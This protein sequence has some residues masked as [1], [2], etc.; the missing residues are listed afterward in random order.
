MPRNHW[1]P[2]LGFLAATAGAL[3]FRLPQLAL[4]PMHCD[5]GNQALKA[6]ILLETGRYKY[7]PQEHHGPLLYYATLPSL[8]LSG[9][10]DFAQSGQLA[11]RIVPVLFGVGLVL[12]LP[13]AADGLGRTPAVFAG[14]L[15]AL[16]PA[17][18]FYSRYYIQEMLLVLLTFAAIASAWR[19]VRSRSLLWAAA[20]GAFFGLMAATK[21]TWCLAAAAMG[22][23]LA[24]S[25]A[26][27][28]WRDG[29]WPDLRPYRRPLPLLV[30]AACGLLVFE[31]FYSSLGTNPCGPADAVLAYGNY[32]RR[33]SEGGI[34][35]HPWYYYLQI[36]AAS[37]PLYLQFHVASRPWRIYFGA[38]TLIVGLAAA[39][40]VAALAAKAAGTR[41][42]PAAG[43]PR[44]VGWDKLAPASAGPPMSSALGGPAAA[45]AAWSHPTGSGLTASSEPQAGFCRFLAFYTLALTAL[46]SAL[47]YKTPWCLLSFLHGMILL[48]GF[49]GWALLRRTPSIPAKVIVGLLLALAAA[50]LARESYLLNYRFYAYPERNPYVYAQASSDV[51]HLTALVE[52]LAQAS[53][54]RRTMLIH[55]VT[56]ENYWPLPWYLRAFDRVGYWQDAAAW[57]KAMLPD[58][59]TAGRIGNLTVGQIGN[60]TVGR[61]GNPSYEPAHAPQAAR[62]ASLPAVL[63]L[64]DDVRPVVD[65]VLGD[66]YRQKMTYGLQPGV[67]LTVY[68]RDDVWEAFLR[69]QLPP[70]KG[71]PSQHG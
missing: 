47:A 24:L 48:A 44:N 45:K 5:E 50:H 9:D 25:L 57:R 22:V 7:D 13:L 26:W 54:Q 34:H 18:V 20:T 28:R 2:V 71:S 17:M 64:T 33:G 42:A 1:L 46:Y 52:R 67:L 36:L 62:D 29:A 43:I 15:T 58:K 37:G 27:G 56:G 70:P 55:V 59:P 21:E 3:A 32:F 10:R 16:S 14:L 6:A 53:G 30:A 12:L 51:V 69:S 63:I 23:G 40:F 19:Y 4:R 31:V 66:H 8:R 61:I 11:Y 41:S 35:W 49:G 38:E 39:G 68:V 60:P 65:A